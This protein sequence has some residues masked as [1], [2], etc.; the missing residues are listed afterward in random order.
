MLATWVLLATVMGDLPASQC[1]PRPETTV[2]TLL[3]LWWPC[4]N[5]GE[6]ERTIARRGEGSV[7][8]L[9][10]AYR[11]RPEL[12][13][14]IFETMVAMGP[15]GQEAFRQL[16]PDGVRA[17]AKARLAEPIKLLRGLGP[18]G[19]GILV[20]MLDYPDKNL[21]SFAAARLQ[22]LAPVEALEALLRA[23]ESHPNEE[24]RIAAAETAAKIE[25][26]RAIPGLLRMLHDESLGPTRRSGIAGLLASVD[27]TRA[28]DAVVALLKDPQV[29]RSIRWDVAQ[30]LK[31]TGRP[32]AVSAARRY[33]PSGRHGSGNPDSLTGAVLTVLLLAFA[34][35]LVV[36]APGAMPVGSRVLLTLV[37]TGA[38]YLAAALVGPYVQTKAVGMIFRTGGLNWPPLVAGSIAVLW[39][40][41]SLS[42]ALFRGSHRED[43]SAL[44]MGGATVVAFLA[45]VV[46]DTKVYWYLQRTIEPGLPASAFQS[47]LVFAATVAGAVVGS[48]WRPF[49]RS[50]PRAEID[51]GSAPSGAVQS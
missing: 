24:V 9:L 35:A 50:G 38:T 37:A 48:Y 3:A 34:C 33:G 14:A 2:E 39:T 46:V 28:L 44:A 16:G 5:K 13:R 26:G 19:T 47:L 45:G 12:R 36:R 31:K 8:E 41:A 17:L 30:D 27:D 10:A 1:V 21:Q 51:A 42:V 15:R 22:E 32:D 6:L 25:P 40:A 29:E 23:M 11:D 7:P 20:E 4:P 43:V 49:G 18:E